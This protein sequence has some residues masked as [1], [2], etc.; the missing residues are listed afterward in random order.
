MLSPLPSRRAFP[1][2]GERGD[3]LAVDIGC[4]VGGASFEL[5]R[6]FP[7]VLGIDYSQHFVNAANV[8]A[9]LLFLSLPFPEKQFPALLQDCSMWGCCRTALAAQAPQTARQLL[10]RP[11]RR[12]QEP[13]GLAGKRPRPSLGSTSERVQG[14]GS[15]ATGERVRG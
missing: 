14:Q 2:A 4:A 15:G 5:A 6:S 12:V 1:Q 8:R 10:K 13:P 11:A 3:P 7:H 9:Q